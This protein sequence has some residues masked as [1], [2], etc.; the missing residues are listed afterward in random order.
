[1]AYP[2]EHVALNRIT[3]HDNGRAVELIGNRGMTVADVLR[4]LMESGSL[5]E[6]EARGLRVGHRFLPPNVE[7]R[8]P[9][10]N[11]GDEPAV[12]RWTGT[13]AAV[14]G[15]GGDANHLPPLARLVV[16]GGQGSGRTFELRAGRYVIGRDPR[17]DIVLESLSVSARHAEVVVDLS[18]RMTIHDLGATN[19]IAVG[20]HVIA[21]CGPLAI[22]DV[23]A[24]G[25]SRLTVLGPS[26]TSS[27][28]GPV[29]ADGR[30]PF[31][32]SAR[33][34]SAPVP[35][36]VVL[37]VVGMVPTNKAR[38]NWITVAVPLAMG[39]ALAF[40]FS[41]AMALFSLLGPLMSVAYFFQERSKI[42]AQKHEAETAIA[43]SA[44][45]VAEDVARQRE[46]EIARQEY[47]YP[48]PG[49]T[50]VRSYGP[51]PELW[52]RRI[53]SCPNG[54]T[55]HV[56]RADLAW[57]P[58]LRGGGEADAPGRP[59]AIAALLREQTIAD[60]PVTVTLS[61]GAALGV[62]SPK[63]T[64]RGVARGIV[65]QLVTLF[66][67]GELKLVVLADLS[68]VD[69]VDEWSWTTILPHAQQPDSTV[70]TAALAGSPVEVEALLEELERT[71]S[72]QNVS[73]TRPLGFEGASRPIEVR[74][75]VVEVGML[76][77]SARSALRRLVDA[78]NT[79]RSCVAVVA[80]APSPD[81]LPSFC[82]DVVTVS[83]PVLGLGSVLGITRRS[84][85]VDVVLAPVPVCAAVQC[86]LNLA[87]LR[88]PESADGV[89]TIPSSVSL[90]PLL[91][92]GASR[93]EFVCE[94]RSR[95]SRGKDSVASAFEAVL[96]IGDDGPF[97]VD[98]VSDG[99]HALVGGTTGSGKSEL[100]RSLVASVAATY[101]PA[102]ANFV[103]VDYKG[104]SAFDVCVGL[105]HVVGM[106]T[107]L[108]EQLGERALLS[109]EAELRWREHLLRDAGA[110][111]YLAYRRESKN[112]AVP[113]A[114]LMVIIDEFATM[115][116]ELPDFLAAL[117]GI[118]QR[119]RS[120]GVHLLLATQRPSGV[121][122]ENI[123]ANTNLRIALRV[124]DTN[125]SQDVLGSPLA[126]GINRRIPGRAYAR[127]GPGELI[128]F[129]AARVVSSSAGRP[130]G[131]GPAV[132]LVEPPS[133]S[134]PGEDRADDSIETLV[135]AVREA[136]LAEGAVPPR[137]PWLEPLPDRLQLGQ[138]WDPL[139]TATR[140]DDASVVIGLLDEPSK[141]T[142]RA[143][144]WSPRRGNVAVCGLL[145]GGA[146]SSLLTFAHQGAERFTPA[147]LHLYGLDFGEGTLGVLTALPHTGAVISPNERDRLVRMI[148]FLRSELDRRRSVST[149]DPTRPTLVVLIDNIASLIAATDEIAPGM[150]DELSRLT[151]DGPGLGC[152]F[153]VAG[154]R[155][156]AFPIAISASLPTKLVFRL[157][158]PSDVVQFGI[159]RRAAPPVIVG[160][161]VAVPEKLPVQM[162]QVTSDDLVRLA[163]RLRNEGQ[164]AAVMSA[165]HPIRS[166][167][168]RVDV[169]DL[170]GRA[171]IG[172][173]AWFLPVGLGDEHLDPVGFSLRAGEH[174]L[175][176][177]PAHSGKSTALRTVGRVALAAGATVSVLSLRKSSLSDLEP[178]DARCTS[179]DDLSM[180]LRKVRALSVAGPHLLLIDD[181]ETVDDTDGLL[182]AIA[183]ERMENL[184][185]VVAARAD[186][187]RSKF[188]HWT[189]EIRRSRTGLILRPVVDLDGD[190]WFTTLP[191]K[192]PARFRDGL[193]YLIASGPAQLIQ[194]AGS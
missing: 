47:E 190:L 177:A 18:G 52:E 187:L 142:Q 50:L 39:L 2:C 145:G 70:S 130:S 93:R 122:N 86:A 98:F 90:M 100:L 110:S 186:V 189:I 89:R 159:E 112:A 139:P 194:V 44:A 46:R 108:D 136:W 31:Y 64:A 137:R 175:V 151:A 95:W 33:V 14:E 20:P 41:P 69:D 30:R 21:S 161:A 150:R 22:G 85:A 88:D 61:F 28:L 166:L 66:G 42:S 43:A 1:M 119:G 135:E 96:G 109:L 84:T 173:D 91:S 121:V 111:D 26:Q 73:A 10:F 17:C 117:I 141:Q 191:R 15:T 60:A 72:Q 23:V 184:R 83:D 54:V 32:R 125:D 53:A 37:P 152:C 156:G 103:L 49:V 78:G 126:A 134:C 167:P 193:G 75:V 82:S 120:L 123:K 3:V 174:V 132:T 27:G 164:T 77:D 180:F 188:G 138:L 19:G 29:E 105:P 102:D 140:A 162:L 169:D 124:Q 176:T 168:E 143:Y 183:A 146:S 181:A 59:E 148:R 6:G 182:A 192:G 149:D 25:S 147:D 178:V 154:D 170:A 56:G 128:R 116:K 107:D 165:P 34:T 55:V 106:V 97:T 40:L 7:L 45:V 63:S 160:R 127:L 11:D 131:T 133:N 114:R 5:I 4:V 13:R 94:L 81:L 158:D 129:Q 79:G 157:A 115:A 153:I 171:H 172:D 99:P 16:S 38:F 87:G 92:L 118:A 8:A 101:G 185:I 80:L 35:A 71:V 24:L 74:I 67:P 144:Q 155:P 113:L 76:T 179:A 68:T 9:W 62:V 12:V 36:D 104:G 163:E 58:T 51:A 57:R 48:D 65:S